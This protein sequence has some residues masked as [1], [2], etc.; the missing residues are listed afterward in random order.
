MYEVVDEFGSI[1]VITVEATASTSPPR[2]QRRR[3]GVAKSVVLNGD[4][5][6]ATFVA[7][8]LPL[9]DMAKLLTDCRG[10]LLLPENLYGYN[11][12]EVLVHDAG[13][14]VNH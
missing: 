12:V 9:G 8:S 10:E 2:S 11:L 14:L 3:G 1:G 4:T 6:E 7:D 13:R 5:G